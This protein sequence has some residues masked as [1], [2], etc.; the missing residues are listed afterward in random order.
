MRGVRNGNMN[1]S[2]AIEATSGD[3][4]GVVIRFG[5]MG[6]KRI[7]DIPTVLPNQGIGFA[8]VI[9]SDGSVSGAFCRDGRKRCSD[10]AGDILDAFVIEGAPG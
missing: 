2:S 5:R 9:D 7:K 4:R 8:G 1:I 10:V 6:W 3:S